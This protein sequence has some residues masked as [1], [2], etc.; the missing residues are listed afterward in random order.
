MILGVSMHLHMYHS[1]FKHETNVGGYH[2]ARRCTGFCWVLKVMQLWRLSGTTSLSVPVPKPHWDSH[3]WMFN[4][5]KV[6]PTRNDLD[7]GLGHRTFPVQ[8]SPPCRAWRAQTERLMA[9][10]SHSRG[11]WVTITERTHAAFFWG[12]NYPAL[13]RW[14]WVWWVSLQ[15]Q[16]QSFCKS[17]GSSSRCGWTQGNCGQSPWMGR[18]RMCEQRWEHAH[19]DKTW[20]GD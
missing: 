19:R 1:S 11:R 18:E 7:I 13:G 6:T 17:K 9:G 3:P 16:Q 12:L 20:G 5:A 10:N 8:P 14:P 15:Q 4:F 2:H